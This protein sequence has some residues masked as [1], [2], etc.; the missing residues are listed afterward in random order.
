MLSRPSLAS[1]AANSARTWALRDVG[2]ARERLPAFAA[3]QLD[4]F[5]RAGLAAAVVHRQPGAVAGEPQPDLAPDT[6]T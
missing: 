2:A 1:V 4:G 5:G 3:D 6:A